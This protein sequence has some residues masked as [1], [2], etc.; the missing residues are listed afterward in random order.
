MSTYE[1]ACVEPSSCITL[2]LHP[3][4][5]PHSTAPE[6]VRALRLSVEFMSG[7]AWHVRPG[8]R[9]PSTFGS[10]ICHVYIMVATGSAVLLFELPQ[11]GIWTPLVQ[12][13]HL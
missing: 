9:V 8:L 12:H 11:I 4:R 1:E 2:L 6:T 3:L 7:I 13:G 5:L 10:C